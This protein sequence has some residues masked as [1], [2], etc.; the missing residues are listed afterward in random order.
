MGEGSFEIGF[1][2]EEGEGESVLI[3]VGL[4]GLPWLNSG[5]RMC[6]QA[7]IAIGAQG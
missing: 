1:G 7:V 4:D 6:G 3:V 5:S 2:K